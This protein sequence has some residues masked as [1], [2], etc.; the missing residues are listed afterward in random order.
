[1]RL[2]CVVFGVVLVWLV[3]NR[4]ALGAESPKA[5]ERPPELE[6]HTSYGE[7]VEAAKREAKML[8]IWFRKP[9][10]GEKLQANLSRGLDARSFRRTL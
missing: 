6:W 9:G 1:M 7:A 5:S 3:P 4:L 10:D 8:L 2:P